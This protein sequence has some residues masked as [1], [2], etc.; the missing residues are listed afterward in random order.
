MNQSNWKLRKADRKSWRKIKRKKKMK[1]ALK[2]SLLKM[3]WWNSWQR[4]ISSIKVR[5]FQVQQESK[6]S[7]T[8]KSMKKINQSKYMMIE[9]RGHYTL[10]RT[11][12]KRWLL[13]HRIKS[14]NKALKVWWTPF[15]SENPVRENEYLSKEHLKSK[16]SSLMF[17]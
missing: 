8:M 2:G 4:R 13:L 5:R 1:M 9:L 3:I 11:S 17:L 16:I 15:L 6:I 7:L 12:F 14:A 10:L